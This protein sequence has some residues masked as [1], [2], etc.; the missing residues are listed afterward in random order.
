GHRPAHR[1]AD[2]MS[3]LDPAFAQIL[4]DRRG[5]ALGRAGIGK[6]GRA[7]MARQIIGDHMRRVAKMLE[8]P[9]PHGM[10]AAEAVQKDERGRAFPAPLRKKRHAAPPARQAMIRL[11][12]D[13]TASSDA[14]TILVLIP[15]PKSRPPGC[16]IST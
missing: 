1:M 8:H 12:A 11:A 5:R 7:A 9:P 10:A 4:K 15:A 3:A 2:E 16:S 14:A 6:I 13:T